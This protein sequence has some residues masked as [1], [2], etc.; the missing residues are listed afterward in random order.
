MSIAYIDPGNIESDLQAGAQGGYTLVWVL[1]WSTV[2]GWFL[3]M[4][5][6][7]LANATGKHM[8]QVCH[9]EVGYHSRCTVRLC[10]EPTAISC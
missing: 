7:R 8:A 1:F 5:A 9:D 10:R 6:V 3:Q 2:L 4:T